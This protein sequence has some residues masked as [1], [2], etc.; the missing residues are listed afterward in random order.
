MARR[1]FPIIQWSG[2]RYFAYTMATMLHYSVYLNILFQV[3]IPKTPL[4]FHFSCLETCLL[5]QKGVN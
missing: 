1:E 2:V 3:F 4:F 5:I